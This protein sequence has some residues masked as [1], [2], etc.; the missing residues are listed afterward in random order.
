MVLLPNGQ[1]TLN[2]LV[3]SSADS[4]PGTV[5]DRITLINAGGTRPYSSTIL[6]NSLRTVSLA[7]A[8][9]TMTVQMN[10]QGN[11]LLTLDGTA[12]GTSA[13][14]FT[15]T[16][17][18]TRTSTISE[19]TFQ[20]FA[21]AGIDLQGARKISVTGVT[22]TN[23]GIGFR[24]SNNL[25]GSGVFNSSFTNNVVGGMLLNA[26]NFLVG[27]NPVGSALQGNTF[28]GSTTGFRGA[29]RTGLS[30]S[31]TT[32]STLVKANTFSGY[33]TAVSLVAATGLRF[34]GSIPGESNSI[35]NASTAGIY[36]SGFCS[37]SFVIKTTFIGVPTA[38]QY[39]V[40]TSRNLTI[41]R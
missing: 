14:G 1:N 5:R 31:G 41:Q 7:T 15:I 32:T 35:S 25:T 3:T 29:S 30:I 21:G 11:N 28:T 16:S 36:A 27:V 9:P 34:G 17:T 8:L 19:V 39:L 38:K 18:S 22:V 10:V 2:Y 40:S 23:S 37:S 13:S 33:P 24:A 12:L 6:V 20:R 26:Q 4:G